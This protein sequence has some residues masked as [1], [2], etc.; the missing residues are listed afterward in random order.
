MTRRLDEFVAE[1]SLLPAAPRVE[2]A[3]Q[4]HDLRRHYGCWAAGGSC[5][6]RIFERGDD[7]PVILCTQLTVNGTLSISEAAEYLAAATVARYLPRRFDEAEPAIWLEHYP[8]DPR[9]QRR[10]G[11][12]PDVAQVR[13]ASWR[14]VIGTLAGRRHVRV[15]APSWQPLSLAEVEALLGPQPGLFDAAAAQQPC[16]T[17]IERPRS[18]S[19]ERPR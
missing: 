7:V 19:P 2:P 8:A 14:P 4:S 6:I 11:G 17:R 15:G 10:G 5:R 9:R 13:F 18:T 3:R 1:W 16:P 12:A